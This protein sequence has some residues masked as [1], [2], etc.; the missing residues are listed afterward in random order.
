MIHKCQGS[1]FC[2]DHGC[3]SSYGILHCLSDVKNH[4]QHPQTVTEHV[5]QTLQWAGNS[6]Q[7][8]PHK[9]LDFKVFIDYKAKQ[10]HID[11]FN[12]C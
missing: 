8:V 3:D 12:K 11:N 1:A 10:P 9:V 6:G 2:R 7:D 5:Y 4:R